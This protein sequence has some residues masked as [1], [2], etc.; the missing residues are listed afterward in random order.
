MGIKGLERFK[1]EGGTTIKVVPE[2]VTPEER[3]LIMEGDL[4][5]CE[6]HCNLYLKRALPSCPLILAVCKCDNPAHHPKVTD[7][8]PCKEW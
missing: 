6:A 7:F 5:Y 1:K 8:P 4:G 3:H 2:Q